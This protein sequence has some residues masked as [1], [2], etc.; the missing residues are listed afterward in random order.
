MI[1]KT[2]KVY[3]CEFCKK[4]GLSAGHIARHEKHCTLNPKRTCGVCKRTAVSHKETIKA[5]RKEYKKLMTFKE[6]NGI[7][8]THTN[9][10]EKRMDDL[11]DECPMCFF[12]ALRLSGN[13]WK[14]WYHFDLSEK[15]QEYWKKEYEEDMRAELYL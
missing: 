14:K 15:M 12:T 1:T 7:L 2:K 13:D 5:I 6:D 4:H 11:I 3:Y 9:A 10:Y 8:M